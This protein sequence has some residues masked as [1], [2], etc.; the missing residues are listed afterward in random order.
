MKKFNFIYGA[1][2]AVALTF[3]SCNL[4]DHPKFDDADAFIAFSKTSLSVNE[5]GDSIDVPV[6]LTS[7][8]GLEGTATIEVDSTST[9]VEG[10]HFSFAGE[11]SVSFTKDAPIQN[12][13]LNIIDNDEFAG[14]VNI[15]L[16]I[17]SATGANVGGV[18]KCTITIADDEHPLKPILG[19][20]KA[21]AYT[22][23]GEFDYEVT[24]A[25]DPSDVQMVW[26][27]DLEPYFGSYG[28]SSAN[29]YNMFY[30]IVND[31][32][33]QITIPA[34]QKLCPG[35]SSYGNIEMVL[36]D[37]EAGTVAEGDII[38]EIKDGGKVLDFVTPWGVYEDGWWNMSIVTTLTKQ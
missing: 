31:D 29:G 7:L 27:Y 8:A 33:T 11:K 16:N 25:M 26:I 24:L 2:A 17:T 10:V 15:V 38:V 30:G 37:A 34:K 35:H 19:T 21:Y 9:A 20:Y 23:R 6:M 28:Y 18:S 36:Y 1:V 5:F 14:D 3:A 22:G 12:L 32:L 13:K 4:N